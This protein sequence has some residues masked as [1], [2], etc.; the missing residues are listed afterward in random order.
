MSAG[1]GIDWQHARHMLNGRLEQNADPVEKGRLSVR[2]SIDPSREEARIYLAYAHDG[3]DTP[4]GAANLFREVPDTA[5]A[6]AGPRAAVIQSALVLRRGGLLHRDGLLP[7]FPAAGRPAEDS[8]FGSASTWAR[9]NRARKR[10]RR[11][12]FPAPVG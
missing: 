4:S 10:R 7:L 5:I 2:R 9:G 12:G 3:R 11:G 6:E 1:R 8:R